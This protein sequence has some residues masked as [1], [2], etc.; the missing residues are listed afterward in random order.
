MKFKTQETLRAE[1]AQSQHQLLEDKFVNDVYQAF[2]TLVRCT[3]TTKMVLEAI[4][5]FAGTTDVVP[6]LELFKVLLDANPEFFQSSLPNQRLEQR[7]AALVDDIVN[8][9]ATGG[10]Y[11]SF[12]LAS[13]RKRLSTN[14]FDVQKLE[15][16]K[17]DILEKQRLNKFSTTELREQLAN[18]RAANA[19]QR[20]VLPPEI[21][22]AVIKK[23]PPAGIKDL[24][25]RFSAVAV[26]DRLFGR[27]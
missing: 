11:T 17:A 19:P 21:T 14:Q 18:Q 2:P 7:K 5:Q 16:R 3:A 9:L 4:Y 10:K 22:A 25:H 15:A 20:P 24:I 26:N 1:R 23:L 12:D 6:T 27:S 8:L 13:E